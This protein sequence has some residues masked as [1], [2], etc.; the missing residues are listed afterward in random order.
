MS[1]SWPKLSCICQNRVDTGLGLDTSGGCS[2]DLMNLYSHA[3]GKGGGR[4]FG[5]LLRQNAKIP[6]PRGYSLFLER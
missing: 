2:G 4:F 3:E 5:V 1:L 6:V